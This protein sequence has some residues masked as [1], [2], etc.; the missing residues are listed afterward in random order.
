MV[1]R[2]IWLIILCI[3]TASSAGQEQK[4]RVKAKKIWDQAPHNAFTDLIKYDNKYYCTFREGGGHVPW[5]DDIDGKIRILVSSN[6][7]KWE[8]VALLE[9]ADYD[10]RDSKLS[11]DPKGRLMVLMGG[12][13]Y[14]NQTRVLINRLTHFSFY[15]RESRTFSSPEPV[16]IDPE[17][18][19]DYDWLWRVTWH[20]GTGYGVVYHKKESKK[21]DLSLVKTQ[22]GIDYEL[23]T[24]LP[25]EG[26][27]GESTVAFDR[28]DNMIILVRVD[29]EPRLGRIGTSS[30]P[31]TSWK[32]EE[33]GLRL[34]GPHIIPFRNDWYIIGTRSFGLD[35]KAKTSVYVYRKEGEIREV[36]ELPSGG[37][38]SYPGLLI[39]GK[40]LWISYYSSHEGRTSVY[41][42]KIP[43]SQIEK[44]IEGDYNPPLRFWEEKGPASFSEIK[45][46]ISTFGATHVTCTKEGKPILNV[47]LSEPYILG[48][49]DKPEKWGFFQFPNIYRSISNKLI[50]TWNMAEDHISSYGKSS[51]RY[52]ISDDNGKTW[53]SGGNEEIGGGL[54]LRD[55][56]RIQ[57]HTPAALKV[58]DL[59]LPPPVR[60][61]YTYPG[62]GAFTYLYKI[63]ELPEALQGVYIARLLQGSSRWNV[64]HA[65]MNDPRAV[66]YSR[67]GLFPVVWWGDMKLI[68]DG[69]VIACTYPGFYQKEDGKIDA[70]GVFFYRSTDQG[71]NWD[72]LSRIDYQPNL[73]ADP[74]GDKRLIRGFG[75]PAF[76]ILADSS[77]L[78][79]MRT[80]DELGVSPMYYCRSRDRG[81][82][83]S[84]PVPFTGNGVLPRLLQLKNG[85]IVL[86]SGRPG[87][88][89][90]FCTDGKG[91]HWSDP[92]EMV[93]FNDI[94][95]DVSCGYTEILAT[96]DDSF[97]LIYSV[98]NHL[99]RDGVTRK[100]IKI[101]EVKV[102]PKNLSL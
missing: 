66:R 98:F 92:F 78:C 10:L 47:R 43:V 65:A 27:P 101:R 34:G 3:C 28:D 60:S 88:Q 19:T 29:S 30:Y 82:T 26:V 70:S 57:I 63:D 75:E 73:N 94:K 61:S 89:L 56:S 4:S 5:P 81:L 100:A 53:K 17:V 8:S 84:K 91:E 54:V 9:K 35:N 50:A 96:G 42:A 62:K 32:W 39:K 22:N 40:E 49:A 90:R 83:W 95:P 6:G 2:Y 67:S 80:S 36:A 7:K 33:T 15:D 13:N 74:N 18:K 12:S 24:R 87:V 102:S 14:N 37:D 68:S 44:T 72:I 38:N 71:R 79:V 48:V 11:I 45:P 97:L 99:N 1:K 55:G 52:M 41:L 20:K 76:E 21:S 85:V 93:P 77:F 16:N 31:Y 46:G 51:K 25:M 59:R 58:D 23:V 64:E 86:V 69:S